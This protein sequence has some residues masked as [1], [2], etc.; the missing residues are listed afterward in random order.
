MKSLSYLHWI[1]NVFSSKLNA[2]CVRRNIKL[3]KKFQIT[4][5]VLKAKL[6]LFASITYLSFLYRSEVMERERWTALHSGECCLDSWPISFVPCLLWVKSLSMRGNAISSGTSMRAPSVITC[7][8]FSEVFLS[9]TW[10][11][12]NIDNFTLFDIVNIRYG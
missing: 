10:N 3:V 7:P 4:S 2:K 6:K 12:L 11:F 5:L 8:T 1:K 9:V